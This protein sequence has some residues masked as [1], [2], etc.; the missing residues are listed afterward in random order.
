MPIQRYYVEHKNK[1]GRLYVRYAKPKL[2]ANGVV[3]FVHGAMIPSI[4]FDVPINGQTWLQFM[5]DKRMHAFAFDFMGYGYSSKPESM[6]KDPVGIPPICRAKDVVVDVETMVDHIKEVTG[7]DKVDLCAFSWGTLT[8]CQYAISNLEK[9]K[10]LTLISPI[11]ACQNPLWEKLPDP[12]NSNILRSSI[13][14]YQVAPKEAFEKML[15]KETK[16]DDSLISLRDEAIVDMIVQD[17][18]EADKEWA[19]K[20]D[21]DGH[22]RL[23]NGYMAD[24]LDV[25]NLKPLYEANQITCP[26][27]IIHGEQDPS[28]LPQDV[29]IL[30]G[31]LKTQKKE[32]VLVKQATNLCILEKDAP[33][34][35]ERMAMFLGSHA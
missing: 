33:R 24:L 15:H 21:K 17:I 32:Y 6:D 34:I 22:V 8:A 29:K 3:V 14:G 10:S 30:Y 25:Y 4:S 16:L 1:N 18:M 23:P 2:E 7:V 11:H 5:A 35:W 31:L 13:G 28:S 27:L 19:T 9:I 20:N 26:T 12:S